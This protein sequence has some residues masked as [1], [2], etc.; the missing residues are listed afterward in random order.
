MENP[1]GN[2]QYTTG[3]LVIDCLHGP[4]VVRMGPISSDRLSCCSN[5]V[6]DSTE[7]VDCGGVCCILIIDVDDVCWVGVDVV[8]A[9]IF[10]N[11]FDTISVL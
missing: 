4:Q 10:L 3:S 7:C 8:G 6:V 5:S 1:L 11:A 2:L 9:T